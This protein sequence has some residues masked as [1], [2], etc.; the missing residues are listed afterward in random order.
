MPQ[1]SASQR[2]AAYRTILDRPQVTLPASVFDAVSARLAASVGFE[3]G[4]FAGSIASAV[5]LGAPDLVV[6]TLPEFA[7][8]ARRIGRGAGLP[9]MVDAD[10]GYGNALNVRRTVEEL[11]AAGVAA[12]SIEDTVL[13]RRYAG[14]QGELIGRDELRD[15]LRAALNAR[16]DPSL[17]VIGRTGAL[18][19]AGLD[20]T[21]VRVHVCAEAGVDAV[22]VVDVTSLE[23][24][25]AL[26]AATSLPLI[27]NAVPRSS[28]TSEL[29]ANGVRVALQGHLPYFVALGALHD[30]Y[31]HLKDGGAPEAL[32]ERALPREAQATALAE[33]DY[34]DLLREYLAV[35]STT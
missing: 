14:A 25:E 6:L 32:R 8:Q 31:R 33:G 18:A 7:A 9:L 12:L 5:V 3:L 4:M 19:R 30:A 23:Q 27:L 22:F 15:K 2:R 11:E 20:E 1:A 10:H 17:T 29:T 28:S 26:H 16:G 21:L 13:P 24:V 34:A 35:D